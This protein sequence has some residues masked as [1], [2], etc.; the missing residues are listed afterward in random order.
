MKPHRN[1]YS[2]LYFC[3]CLFLFAFNANAEDGMSEK[4]TEETEEAVEAVEA[5]EEDIDETETEEDVDQSGKVDHVLKPVDTGT[6]LGQIGIGLAVSGSMHTAEMIATHY[7]VGVSKD[8][9]GVENGGLGSFLNLQNM[10]VTPLT[11]AGLSVLY[12]NAKEKREISYTKPL[13][14]TYGGEILLCTANC[15]LNFAAV[16]SI[17]FTAIAEGP[18][19]TTINSEAEKWMLAFYG[20]RAARVLNSAITPALVY[21]A[22][23]NATKDPLAEN[24]TPKGGSVKQAL[25]LAQQMTY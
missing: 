14:W 15:M 11:A 7:K 19:S 6:T 23:A 18:S 24:P 4:E 8:E 25:K 2:N 20:V 12:G 1:K 17:C 13:L 10:A 5:V 21:R 9:R 16:G 3:V 22:E